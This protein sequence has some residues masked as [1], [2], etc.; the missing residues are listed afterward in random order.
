MKFGVESGD[1]EKRSYKEDFEVPDPRDGH[2]PY[3]AAKRRCMAPKVEDSGMFT[4]LVNDTITTAIERNL[5]EKGI[6][7][8]LGDASDEAGIHTLLDESLF[9]T[10]AESIEMHV[11][12]GRYTSCIAMHQGTTF[13]SKFRNAS[14]YGDKGH[15]TEGFRA[16]KNRNMF[17][18]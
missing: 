7:Q 13:N 14:A 18:F 11:R 10:A 5:D 4:L 9:T 6:H 12:D 16:H 8:Y 1:H 15:E 3:D 2:I 17:G